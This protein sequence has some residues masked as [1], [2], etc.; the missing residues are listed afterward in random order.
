ML[1]T[2]LTHF[3]PICAH[4]FALT[5]NKNDSLIIPYGI[6]TFIGE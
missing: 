1:R 5:L 6:Q 3:E 2:K 4:I